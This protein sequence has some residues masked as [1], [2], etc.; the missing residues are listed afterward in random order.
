MCFK[1]KERK[2]IIWD[3]LVTCNDYIAFVIESTGEYLIS[4]AL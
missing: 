1:T 4:V 2:K 3:T